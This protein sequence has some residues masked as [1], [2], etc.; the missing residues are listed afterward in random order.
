MSGNKTAA[1]DWMEAL[2]GKNGDGSGGYVGSIKSAFSTYKIEMEEIN[3]AVGLSMHGSSDGS[4]T[5][6]KAELLTEIIGNTDQEGLRGV[7]TNLTDELG[8]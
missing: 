7:V 4:D 3:K 6:S 5:A 1:A 2:V 8:D